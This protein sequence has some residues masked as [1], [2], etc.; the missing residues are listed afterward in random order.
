MQLCRRQVHEDSYIKLP[1]LYMLA[2]LFA[3]NDNDK[4]GD[5]GLEHPF[6]QL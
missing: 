6:A 4:L 5:F 3:G 2:G 1:P